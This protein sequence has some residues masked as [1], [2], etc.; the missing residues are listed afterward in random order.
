MKERFGNHRKV[1]EENQAGE[2]QER[3][4]TAMI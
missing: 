1:R 3:P 4:A 2:E